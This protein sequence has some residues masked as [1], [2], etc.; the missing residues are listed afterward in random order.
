MRTYLRYRDELVVARG[1]QALL[2][3]NVQLPQVLSD[4]TGVSGLA[5]IDAILKGER[6]P[7]KLAA[8]VDRRVRAGQQTIQAAL[9]GDYREEHL[10]VLGQ[11]FE[12]YHTYE[13]RIAACD[14]QIVRA[15]ATLPA[16]VEPKP[17]PLPARKPGR[18]PYLDKMAG[19]D[20]RPELHEIFGVDLTGIEGIGVLNGSRTQCQPLPQRK[21]VLLLAGAVPGQPHQ[22]G[23]G[24][25]QPNPARGQPGGRRPPPGG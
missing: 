18:K 17:Q 4:V 25:E 8:L 23:Q 7:G 5:I 1:T 24:V 9:R 19:V 2:Q 12:L 20:L 14:G 3:M 16:R 21:T 13:A 22:R 6:D 11:A 15:L 10:F